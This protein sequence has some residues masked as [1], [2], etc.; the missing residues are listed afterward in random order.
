[1]KV[2]VCGAT[3]FIGR[4]I[5]QA[6]ARHGHQVVRGVRQPRQPGDRQ[7]D[8][9]RPAS[10]ADWAARLAGLD[11]VVNVVG[12]LRDGR[13]NP[14]AAV[15]RD[16]PQTL[17][18]ACAAHGP[19]HVVQLS[20]LGIEGSDTVYATTKRAADEHLL[21]LHRAGR[22][23]ATVLRP[24]IVY[25]PGG[26][27]A[28]LFDALARW[29]V[30]VLPSA[31]RHSRV[32]PLHVQDL[33][34]LVCRALETLPAGDEPLAVVGPRAMSLEAFVATLRTTR[35]ARAARVLTLPEPLTRWSARL[36]DRLP[37]T[38]WGTEALAL[39]QQDSTADPGPGSALLGHPLRDPRDF[40]PC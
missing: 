27:S 20:A 2:L 7:V 17:F 28:A 34:D 23:Q 13:G 35:S 37:F 33:A 15:H 21:A 26:A 30:L 22:L 4:H 10:T 40:A 19:R 29:P 38:P 9:T 36:G 11:A 5:E 14:I 39:L 31:V 16:G 1:M 12:V 24:S 25:G 3:G 8:F 32:Q 18:D 6:L